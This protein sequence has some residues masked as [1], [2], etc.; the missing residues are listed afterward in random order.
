MVT[1]FMLTYAALPL[2]RY[3]LRLTN[4]PFYRP[5]RPVLLAFRAFSRGHIP[6]LQN[7]QNHPRNYSYCFIQLF[8]FFHKR[9]LIISYFRRQIT[10]TKLSYKAQCSLCYKY[11]NI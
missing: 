2:L 6:A 10:T 11:D 4:Q 9:P 5:L 3:H 7:H 8:R 1:F